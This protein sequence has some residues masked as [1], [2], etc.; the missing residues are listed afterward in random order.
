[1]VIFLE[2]DEEDP[3]GT[4]A[5]WVNPD[6]EDSEFSFLWAGSNDDF[7]VVI[8]VNKGQLVAT[9]S[10]N[11]K[12]YVIIRNSV[13]EYILTDINVPG[14]PSNENDTVLPESQRQNS[15]QPDTTSVS[16]IKSFDVTNKKSPTKQFRGTQITVLDVLIV[17][18]EIARIESG[19]AA[20]D[21]NDTQD[22][23]TNIIQVVDNTNLALVN[24]EMNTRITR[25]HV[26][27]LNGFTH[28]GS[29]TTTLQDLKNLQSLKDLRT[30]VGAVLCY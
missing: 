10:G 19:G 16:H 2:I 13:D 7:D 9:L 5:F 26:A 18:T 28:Q 23:E 14:L 27:K 15:Q 21:P 22:I 30:N 12:R 20:N 25:F 24:S 17:Y 1:V 6:A 11:F 29:R 3:P 8:T 4:P